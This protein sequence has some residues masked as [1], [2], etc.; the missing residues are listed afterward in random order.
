MKKNI[1]KIID[2]IMIIFFVILMGYH[3]TGNKVHEVLGV[4]IF[5]LFVVHNILNIKWYKTIF[6]GKYGFCRLFQ[7]LINFLLLASMLGMIISG[8]MISSSVFQFL[9]IPT[10][11][12]G[13]SLHMLSTSWGFVLMSIHIGLHLNIIL[14]KLNEKVKNSTFEYIYY[15]IICLF[16]IYGLYVFISDGLWKDM[17][18]I[19]KFKFFNYNQNSLLFYLGQFSIF[20]FLSF[21]IYWILCL[22]KKLKNSK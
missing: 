20:L 13:R 4:I 1:R 18:L 22:I 15:L 5:V 21:T 8:V 6:K 3:I 16:M 11:M 9:N 7:I 12:F 14:V 2:I 19:T 10:T 17:L